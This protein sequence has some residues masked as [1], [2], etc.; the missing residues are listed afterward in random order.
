ML[1]KVIALSLIP[2]GTALL[3]GALLPFQVASNAA[4]G[5]ALGHPLWGALV[6]LTV[7]MLVLLPL[8]WFFKA[9]G[10]RL[11]SALEGPWWLWI[12]GVFGALYVVSS[13]ALTPKLGAASFLVL[14]VAGQTIAAI[15]VDQFGLMGLA[16]RP[17]T[18]ARVAGVILIIAGA[19]LMQHTGKG[20]GGAEQTPA[21]ASTTLPRVSCR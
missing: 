12:G 13:T 20:G 6:S 5:K 2:T 8:L 14:V 3:A 15:L 18:L 7:S 16:P 10:P 11:S 19:V 9:P 4:V 1:I 17:V 21:S